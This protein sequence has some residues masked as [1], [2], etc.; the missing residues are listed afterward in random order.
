MNAISLAFGNIFAEL[1]NLAVFYFLSYRSLA[2]NFFRD[3][4]SILKQAVRMGFE[5]LPIVMCVT[6]FVGMNIVVQG[7]QVMRSLGAQDMVG[8]FLSMAA[9]RELAPIMAAALVGAKSGCSIA[10]ELATMRIKEQIDALEVMSVDP[11]AYLVAPRLV[12]SLFVVP[13]IAVVALWCCIGAGYVVAVYQFDLNGVLFMQQ[14][15][16]FMTFRDVVNVLIKS[17]FFAAFATPILCYAGFEARGGAK[18]VGEATNRAV[19]WGA[20]VIVTTNAILTAIMY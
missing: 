10:S 7:Y 9:V 4:D 3:T 6:A 8:M 16:G 18:G 15:F 5:S 12:A 20:I 2:H 14:I 17:F 13:M 19:V 11:F 1:G